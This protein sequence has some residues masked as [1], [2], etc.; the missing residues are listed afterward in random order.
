MAAVGVRLFGG[1]EVDCFPHDHEFYTK[2]NFLLASPWSSS[3]EQEKK[4]IK[5]KEEVA[6]LRLTRNF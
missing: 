3:L 2:Y 1:P 6:E 4:V 5:R